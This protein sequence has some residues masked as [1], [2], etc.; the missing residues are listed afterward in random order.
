MNVKELE[1]KVAVLE[2]LI[3]ES[4]KMNDSYEELLLDAYGLLQIDN[5][6]RKAGKELKEWEKDRSEWVS[7]VEY[8]LYLGIRDPEEDEEIEEE[9]GEDDS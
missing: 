8:V 7:K 4:A 2:E 5:E 6:A 1:D 9:C 3:T